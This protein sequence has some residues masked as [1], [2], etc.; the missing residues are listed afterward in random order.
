MAQANERRRFWRAAFSA[1]VKL[2]TE[3]GAVD[4]WLDDI[5]L[6]GAL[7]EMPGDW[8][9]EAGA[10]CKLHLRLGGEGDEEIA[11]WARIAHVAG[12]K[13]GLACENIDLDSITHLRRLVE[14]NAG[15]PGLLERELSALLEG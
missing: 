2:V 14:L 1:P 5:S 11:M 12:N 10:R 9:G 3:A 8:R 7:L 6:K 13:V 4:A 15:D